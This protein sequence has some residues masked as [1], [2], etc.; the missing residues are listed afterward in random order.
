M[1]KFAYL[2]RSLT[3]RLDKRRMRCPNCGA[4]S[5]TIIDTK[6]FITDLRRCEICFLQYRTPTDDPNLNSHYYDTEYTQGMTTAIP[7]EENLRIL[8]GSGFKNTDRDF[9]YYL[10]VL[11]K[12][13]LRSNDKLFDFGC[14]WGY[15]SYQFALAGFDVRSFEI[16]AR[17]RSFASDHLGVQVVSDMDVF[18]ERNAQQFDCFFSAHVLEHVPSPSRIFGYAHSLLK[19]GGLFVAF[20]P[21]GSQEHRNVSKQWSYLWGEVHP[22]F[23]DDEFFDKSFDL[24]PRSI[25][26]SPI[27]NA[28]VSDRAELNR[29]GCLDGDEL[30]FVARKT[31]QSWS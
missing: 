19:L 25:G 13:G 2:K 22:N 30:F 7:S 8:K 26:S 17:R 29:L 4:A 3:S 16:A 21:N 14:S 11:H 28:F 23:L 15:G 12:L 5:G 20:V 6:Y 24:V 31:R 1:G 10:S 9:S 27:T 18:S